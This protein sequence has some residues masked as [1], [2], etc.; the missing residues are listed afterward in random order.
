MLKESLREMENIDPT[1]RGEERLK[2]FIEIL[3]ERPL[4]KWVKDLE[5]EFPESK[6]YLVGGIVRDKLLGRKSDDLDFVICGIPAKKLH[7]F[8]TKRGKV[9]LV[10]TTFGV[11]KFIPSGAKIRKGKALDVAMPRTEVSTGPGYREFEVMY[12]HKLPVEEDLSRRDFTVNAMATDMKTGKLIDIFGGKEDLEKRLIRT[13]GEPKDRFSE[14]YSRILRALRFACQLN[15]K[16]EDKTWQAIKKYAPKILEKRLFEKRE[17]TIVPWEAVGKE[18]MKT[19]D[20]NPERTLDLYDESGILKLILPEL[21]A[22]KGVEQ[23]PEFHPEGDVWVHTKLAL[24]HTP[25]EVSSR[26]KLAILLHDIGKPSTQRTPEEHGTDRIR[27]DDHDKVGAEMA[28]KICKRLRLSK[29]IQDQ[30]CWLIRHHLLFLTG[31]I[32]QMRPKTIKKYFIDNPKLGDELLEIYRIETLASPGVEQERSFKEIKKIKDYIEDMRKSFRK[33]KTETFTH[34]ISG[35]DVMKKFNLK[36]GPEVGEY[37]E[38]ANRFILE[39]ITE[40]N[41]E[42]KKE[43]VLEYLKSQT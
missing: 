28:E 41:K 6:T 26:L 22:C 4:V 16:V 40:K 11:R 32:F 34:I 7:N 39:Y 18:F 19:L 14:D 15:F 8:L 25:K 31:D 24:H 17:R 30:V 5:S 1:T 3:R 29:K 33:T 27:F 20:A 10:G 42:P 37:L 35:H 13:V 9:E 12:D 23:P 43:E 2:R 38:K 21:E 36:P